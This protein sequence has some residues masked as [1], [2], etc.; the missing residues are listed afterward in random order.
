MNKRK[1]KSFMLFC[2]INFW[3]SWKP[4]IIEYFFLLK[5]VS[6]NVSLP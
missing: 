2:A 3:G 1:I 4:K 6:V 5:N